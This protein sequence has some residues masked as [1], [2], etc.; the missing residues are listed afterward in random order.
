MA[1]LPGCR[2][3]DGESPRAP[4]PTMPIL[5]ADNRTWRC[6]QHS[7]LTVHR[8]R[9]SQ[10]I[11]FRC[12]RTLEVIIIFTTCMKDPDR[13]QRQRRVVRAASHVHA[14]YMAS[15]CQALAG[16]PGCHKILP[17]FLAAAPLGAAPV[18]ALRRL[19]TY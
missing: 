9:V 7:S 4:K 12:S 8:S 1:Q 18:S 5:T 17:E 3:T 11:D 16:K 10:K 15:A 2:G 6:H 14:P 19:L 13:A